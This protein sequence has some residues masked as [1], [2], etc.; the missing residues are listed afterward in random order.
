MV[1]ESA[2]SGA[3][4]YIIIAIIVIVI[5]LCVLFYATKWCRKKSTLPAPVDPEKAEEEKPL[6]SQS[7][8]E[9]KDDSQS[10]KEKKDEPGTSTESPNSDGKY[11][12]FIM[13]FQLSVR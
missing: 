3:S 11:S 10:D 1:K 12:L 2:G 9:K 6:N 5:L 4:L 8:N 13:N 7:D